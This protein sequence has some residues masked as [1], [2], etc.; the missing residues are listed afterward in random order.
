MPISSLEQFYISSV[1][2]R[3]PEKELT[4]LEL[5]SGSSSV[6][7]NKASLNLKVTAIDKDKN[8]IDQAQSKSNVSYLNLD[9]ADSKITKNLTT[10]F[11]LIFDAHCFQC[12]TNPEERA[13]AWKNVLELLSENGIF[14]A[15]MMVQSSANKIFVPERYIPES[16]DLEKEIL[17]SG[18]KIN[19]FF[20]SRDM[21]FDLNEEHDLKCDVL[22][23]MATK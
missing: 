22:R 19:F 23:V 7:E 8:L 13:R 9:I 18:L 20:I 21:I 3:L 10:K 11:D 5:G 2:T 4:V 14:A 12:I 6:F 1:R 15:E 16:L 17:S